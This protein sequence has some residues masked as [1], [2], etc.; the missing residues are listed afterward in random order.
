MVHVMFEKHEG[1]KA[2]LL[3]GNA[4]VAPLKPMTIPTGVQEQSKT[5]NIAPRNA[6]GLEYL[7]K[8]SR[9]RKHL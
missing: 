9:S 8:V 1:L 6:L 5:G 7:Q 4:R 2:A 3:T